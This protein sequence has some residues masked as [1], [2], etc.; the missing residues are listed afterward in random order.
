MKRRKSL[1]TFLTFVLIIFTTFTYS[2][3]STRFQIITDVV[4]R[5]D[6]DIR[7]T[8]IS[9]DSTS[10]GGLI[11]FDSN[12]TK[13]TITSG[14]KLPNLNSTISYNVT[15]TNKGNI[16]QAIYNITTISSSNNN[17]YYLVDDKPINEALPLIVPLGTSK[18]IKITYKT[19]SP[20]TETETI[21]NSFTFK[22]VYYV[23]YNLKGGSYTNDQNDL[24]N[25]QIKYEDVDL[26]LTNEKPTKSKY[27]FIGWTDEQNGTV[28]KYPSGSTYSLNQN[29]ILYAVYRQGEA[30]FLSGSEFNS[31]IKILAGNANAT[32]ST[33]DT[34]ITSIVRANSLPN[35]F[36]PT[37]ANIVSTSTSDFPIYAWYSNGTIYYYTVVDNPYMNSNGNHMFENLTNVES[38]D[39]NTIN[40]SRTTSMWSTFLNCFNLESLDLSNFNTEN[41]TSLQSTFQQCNSLESLDLS[42]FNTNKVTKMSGMFLGCNSLNDLTFGNNF[43][44]SNVT[45]MS[46]MFYNCNS[47]EELD[48]SSFDLSKITVAT[49]MLYNMS[50]LLSLKT[51]SVYPNSAVIDLPTTLYDIS[52]NAYT[53]I[54]SSSPTETWLKK[55]YGIYTIT[56]DLNG[57]TVSTPNPTSYYVDSS[58]ITLNNPTKE[59]Y[60]FSGWSGKNLL[61][62]NVTESY[63]SSTNLENTTKRTFTPNTYVV[64]LAYNNYFYPNNIYRNSI[65]ITDNSVTFNGKNGYGLAYPLILTAG[66]TYTL[67]YN[68][69]SDSES[70]V[71]HVNIQ[72]YLEDG[73]RIGNSDNLNNTGFNQ[74]VFEV[75]SN[76]YYSVITLCADSSS[77][78]T[79]TF[80]NV[81]IEKGNSYTAYEQ[82]RNKQLNVTIPTGSTGNKN[83]VANYTANTYNVV[84]DKNDTNATGTMSNQNMVYDVDSNLNINTFINPA[85]IFVGWNTKADGTGI[86]YLDGA[87]VKNLT[88]IN[89]GTVT[90]YAQ[91]DKVPYTVT[92]NTNGGNINK[93]EG[94][95]LVINPEG[96]DSYSVNNNVYTNTTSTAYPSIMLPLDM[97]TNGKTYTLKYKFKK[98]SGTLYTLGGHCQS[99]SII[100]LKVDGKTRSGSYNLINMNDDNLVHEIEYKFVF[101]SGN[102]GV[103]IQ[104]NRSY[105]S[106]INYDLWNIEVIEDNYVATKTV[107]YISPYGTLPTPLKEG[108]TFKGWNGKNIF[109]YEEILN[110]N[111]STVSYEEFNGAQTISW[112]NSSNTSTQ[113]FLQGYF[114][115]NTQYIFHGNVASS[116]SNRIAFDIYYKDGSHQI[117]DFGS[118]NHVSSAP[119]NTFYDISFVSSYGKTIDFIRG[120]WSA[121]ERVYMD[122]NSFIIEEGTTAT[123]YEPYY[124]TSGTNVT[125][126]KNHTLT[127]IWEVNNYEIVFDK[128]TNDATGT[129]S[130]LSMTYDESK[131]LTT[132]SFTRTGYT[133]VGWNT[134]ADGTG[135]AYLDGAS[136]S[137]VASSGTVTLYAQWA[138]ISYTVTLDS[139]E[140]NIMD[141]V[142]L[143]GYDSTMERKN[144][145]YIVSGT[146]T[147]AGIYVP[148]EA[149]E[150][151]KTYILRF[152]IQKVD[153]S[154][155]AL[156][157]HLAHTQIYF[158]IDGSNSSSRYTDYYSTTNN[159]TN[160]T[161]VHT[162]ELKFTYNG[163]TS[164]TDRN[165]YIQPNRA[166]TDYFK[167]KIFDVE[168]EELS[169]TKTV[170]FGGTYGTLPTPTTPGYQ[171]AGWN[172]KNILNYND[173]LNEA[174]AR[175]YSVDSNGNISFS[176]TNDYRAWNYDSSNWK[177]TLGSGDYK[178]LIYFS[179]Q[180]SNGATGLQLIDESNNVI[181]LLSSSSLNGVSEVSLD[182]S[183]QSTTNLGI[184]YKSIDAVYKIMIIDSN[185]SIIWE[186]YYVTSSTPLTRNEDHTLYAKWTPNSYSISFNK[187]D[188]AATGTMNN[189]SMT[190]G[191]SSNLTNNS[192]YKRGYKFVGW[193][194]ASDGTGTAYLN[195]A[196]VSNLTNVNNGTVTL[197]AQWEKLM[198]EDVG[199]TIQDLNCEDV[200]CVIDELY[201]MLY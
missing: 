89:N 176:G 74:I 44:T 96:V 47:I 111:S 127:A 92:F 77:I 43:D 100:Y 28:V 182:F 51:P 188:N 85:Y 158:K 2:A 30:T 1:I 42:S 166:K 135:T 189:Q 59:G 23:D 109:D 3:L 97:F 91:W 171:F 27:A 120:A 190:Y 32:Y 48:I 102:G 199:H 141:N 123:I 86:A 144:D 122:I 46:N 105:G 20:F 164:G 119:A 104:P 39:I 73:T 184:L 163:S 118:T 76:T 69:T 151:G 38:I 143:I 66:E 64:G 146:T 78:L 88:S 193:N 26:T 19:T 138:V 57:G 150:G 173:L 61:N 148:S 179:T 49:G 156:G 161:N 25:G 53:S 197:Y 168:L 112:I 162:V 4:I 71:P 191:T 170:N 82:Y 134:K 6:A 145:Q 129:M 56:Y 34:N 93:F 65:N 101:Y 98:N 136:V 12:Y 172:G 108:Y 63:P 8:D 75:P 116:K 107:Y 177:F 114:K 133:F 40:T 149:F 187:N 50:S 159:I 99:T 62:P 21:V 81:Q 36:T 167:V 154:L 186:P 37:N 130:N 152:K 103:Y 192:Y 90:L 165:I 198:A 13:N 22:K 124:V 200:Q 126:A 185:N 67:S 55:E 83:Y 52:G 169:T 142:A 113:K 70:G 121:D 132:N 183:I 54:N 87:S 201:Y 10:N 24:K 33:Q 17:I 60:T 139:N 72:F 157:G 195:G 5:V 35:G 31:K 174:T 94:K 131:A 80:S 41:V 155:T 153:G 115:D 29:I 178:L 125:Q 15:I 106:L 137:N 11:S 196:S 58:S 16:D 95:E 160:D 117:F 181:G 180:S 79:Y 84:F 18:T 110:N 9:L 128:N 140:G 45:D 68:A 147:T 14:F 175:G 7:I 194:T